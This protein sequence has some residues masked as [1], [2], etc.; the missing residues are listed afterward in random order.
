MGGRVEA[1]LGAARLGLNVANSHVYDGNLD[2]NRLRLGAG[3]LSINPR[4]AT[5]YRI[6]LEGFAPDA[7]ALRSIPILHLDYPMLP[8][9]LRTGFGALDR[10]HLTYRWGVRRSAI[11]SASCRAD[12]SAMDGWWV[13]TKPS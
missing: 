13:V 11:Y 3:L 4:F 9:T 2:G 8:R 10:C 7:L 1:D 6:Y 12:L 5:T